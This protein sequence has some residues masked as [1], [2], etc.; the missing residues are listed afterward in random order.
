VVSALNDRAFR[1]L[2]NVPVLQ[3]ASLQ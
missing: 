2:W 3:S 1:A